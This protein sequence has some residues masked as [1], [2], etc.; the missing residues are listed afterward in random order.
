MAN[1]FKDYVQKAQGLS[2][3]TKYLSED[4][5]LVMC[6]VVTNMGGGSI[7]TYKIDLI[8]NTGCFLLVPPP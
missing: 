7:K 1:V 5:T 4:F 6:N 3:N 8:R 2:N